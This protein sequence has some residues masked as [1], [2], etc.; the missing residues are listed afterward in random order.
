MPQISL[1]TPILCDTPEKV[2]WLQQMLESVNRQTYTDYECILIDDCSPQDLAPIKER[3][4]FPRFR[5][6]KT[7]S[8]SE[9]ALTRNTAVALAR[10][11]GILPLDADDMLADDL[12]LAQMVEAWEADKTKIIYGDLQRL[13]VAGDKFQKEKPIGLPEYKFEFQGGVL[14]FHGIMPVSCLHSVECHVKAGGWKPELDSGLEDI[15][16]W[17]AAGKAGF[18][19]VRI[20]PATLLYRRHGQSRAHNLRFVNKQ[21][22]VMQQR[23]AEMHRDIYYEGRFPVGCCGSRGAAQVPPSMNLISPATSL[24]QFS[25]SEKTWV[26]Y[27]GRREA[28]FGVVGQFTSIS[29]VVKGPG[30]KL[31]VHLNDLP[32]FRRSG[33]GRDFSIGVAPPDDAPQP[34]QPATT[35]NVFEAPAPRLAEIERLDEL[36][37]A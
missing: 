13:V 23:I 26:E 28:S 3:Y 17:I 2:S 9:P 21:E 33:R 16:Y 32:R 10:G 4:R 25:A 36:A 27:H 30:H 7:S 5:W 34:N 29:Y 20:P 35:G 22:T 15:E 24:D 6:F 31:E 18:C 1:I 12:T 37:M 11:E 8:R 14:D 19:G